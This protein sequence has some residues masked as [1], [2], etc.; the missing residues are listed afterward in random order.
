[1][2]DTLA[3]KL[4]AITDTLGIMFTGWEATLH[5][6]GDYW[7]FRISGKTLR[8]AEDFLKASD[9]DHILT[10]CHAAISELKK[11]PALQTVRIGARNRPSRNQ[12][13]R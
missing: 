12:G 6:D 2:Q 10:M 4:E 7:T 9:V 11:R 5:D 3:D 8:F 1:M 13:H